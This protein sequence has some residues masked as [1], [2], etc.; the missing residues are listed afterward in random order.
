MTIRLQCIERVELNTAGVWHQTIYFNQNLNT[1]IGGRSTGSPPCY[2]RLQ[3][4]LMKRLALK[5][6]VL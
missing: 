3:L 4:N 2:L 1:I 5:M 6:I